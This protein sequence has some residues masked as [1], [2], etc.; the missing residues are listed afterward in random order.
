MPFRERVRVVTEVGTVSRT[1][2]SMAASVDINAIM[3]KFLATGILT[4]QK[5]SEP[6]Y[7][8]FSSGMDYHTA[9][10]KIQDAQDRFDDLPAKVRAHVD[11][12]PGKLL[13]LAFDPTRR[14]EMEELGLIP[15]LAAPVA[16]E[17][18]EPPETPVEAP[19]TEG[20]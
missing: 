7:G 5:S 8:D 4:H 13:D 17:G 10:N 16:G 6:R 19:E 1:K 11:N 3:R 12:D 20:E 9:L 18:G 14:S 15:P 2:Q